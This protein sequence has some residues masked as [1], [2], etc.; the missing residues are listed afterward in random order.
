MDYINGIC[1]SL[2]SVT[3]EKAKEY[4]ENQ[5]IQNEYQNLTSVLESSYENHM[6]SLSDNN[7]WVC[8]SLDVIIRL[9]SLIWLNKE[10]INPKESQSFQ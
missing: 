1:D 3:K 10:N 5:E 6:N 4:L 8:Y 9:I 2:L 7:D